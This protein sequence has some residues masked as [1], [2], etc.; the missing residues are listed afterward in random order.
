[1][2][3]ATINSWDSTF[4]EGTGGKLRKLVLHLG[5]LMLTSEVALSHSSLHSL[6]DSVGIL[7]CDSK[8]MILPKRVLLR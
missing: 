2:P 4:N 3:G 7:V 1:V 6:R 5:D 8:S